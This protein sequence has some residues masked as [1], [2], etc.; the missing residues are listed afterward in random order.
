MSLLDSIKHA[1]S[2]VVHFGG[3]VVDDAKKVGS[4]LVNDAEKVGST[5][6]GGVQ[7]PGDRQRVPG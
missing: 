1:G 7:A 3:D 2:N 6:A 4:T 5:V